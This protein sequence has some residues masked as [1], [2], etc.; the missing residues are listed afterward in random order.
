MNTWEDIQAKIWTCD[1]CCKRERVACNIRQQTQK[2]DR[3]VKLLL[4]GIAPPYVSGVTQKTRAKSATHDANDN[5]RK[6]IEGTLHYSWNDL[7]LRGLFFVHSVK[8]AIVP[9]DRHQNPPDD[10]VDACAPQYFGE[11]L[12][13]I[14][15]PRVVAFGKASHRALVRV[16]GVT[17]PKD[18]G[19][20]KPVATLVKQTRGGL[21]VQANGWEFQSHVSP[22]PLVAGKPD[23]VAA[24]VLREAAQLSGILP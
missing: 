3:P 7:L 24:D 12:K 14:Q 20:S 9:K 15:P 5:L 2:P 13:F 10:V 21:E 19:V 11:E 16:P 4:I 6:F 18:L 23:P 17:A 8:C 22:F 1:L